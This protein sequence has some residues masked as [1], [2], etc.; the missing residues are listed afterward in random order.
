MK[1][2]GI[3]T[4]ALLV[5]S[6]LVGC[7]QEQSPARVSPSTTPVKAESSQAEVAAEASLQVV[8]GTIDSCVPGATIDPTVSWQR[9][10]PMVKSTKVTTDNPANPDER[11]FARAGFGG[12][13][14]AGNWVVAGTRFHVYDDATGR[15]LASYT[16]TTTE[17]CAD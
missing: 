3:L 16:V 5:S 6:V 2:I 17:K 14:R 12:S 15:A 1:T 10:N 8:P 11:L 9:I 7:G 4:L 13:A